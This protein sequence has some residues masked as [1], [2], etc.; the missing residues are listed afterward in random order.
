MQIKEG[1][2]YLDP[3]VLARLSNIKLIARSVVEGFIS[4]LHQSPYKGFS[5]EF[6]EYREYVPGDD[7]KH[8]DWKALARTDR[9]Y[10]KQYQEETNLKAYILIDASASMAYSSTNLTKF[11]YSCYLAASLSYLMT[12]QQDSVGLVLFDKEIRH[13][14]PAKSSAQ[15]LRD[16]LVLLEKAEPGK[17]TGL[18]FPP[19]KCT[20]IADTLH[21]IAE[22]IK[23]RGLII[24]ISDLFEKQAEVLRGL[25]H[26]RHFKHEVIVF[27][28]LDHSELT[29]PFTGLTTFRNMES[30]EKMMIEPQFFREEYIKAVTDFVSKYKKECSEQLIDY[31][32]ADTSRPFDMLLASY[33]S[34]RVKLR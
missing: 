25:Q 18:H 16:M 2:R 20:G 29:F 3:Q 6:A 5:V 4:G 34:K 28:I 21:K 14:V 32:V 17:E 9:R 30:D 24:L 31:I 27:H 8:F 33:L 7:L 15:H 26:F 12:R 10:I 11:E 23:K 22:G 1:R 13:H 19:D